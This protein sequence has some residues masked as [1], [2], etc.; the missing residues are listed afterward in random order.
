MRLH[1]AEEQSQ[2]AHQ[3]HQTNPQRSRSHF[4][5]VI[6]AYYPLNFTTLLCSPEDIQPFTIYCEIHKTKPSVRINLP[7]VPRDVLD[8][9]EQYE[10]PRKAFTG[11]VTETDENRTYNVLGQWKARWLPKKNDNL[12]NNHPREESPA[13]VDGTNKY[14]TSNDES[15]NNWQSWSEESTLVSPITHTWTTSLLLSGADN[16][17]H[18]RWR[19]QATHFSK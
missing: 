10:P 18:R 19:H 3:N 12:L 4:K 5:H 6:P 16:W 9:V 15:E 17:S 8:N 14:D 13:S 1:A 7:G 11:L 2:E